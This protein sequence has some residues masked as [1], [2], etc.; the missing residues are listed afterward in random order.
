MLGKRTTGRVEVKPQTARPPQKRPGRKR[1]STWIVVARRLMLL[2][3]CVLLI[4][5][6]QQ[7]VERQPLAAREGPAIGSAT[8]WGYQLQNVRLKSISNGI[9]VLVVDYSRD[10]SEAR[11]FRRDEIE[12][13]RTKEDGSKRIV[14]AYMSVGEAE[15]Y[16][17]YWSRGWV[18]GKP[19]WLGPENPEWKG[20]FPVRYWEKGWRDIIMRPQVSL[21]E[22][23]TEAIRPSLRPYLDRIIEAGFDGV[24]LDRVDAFDSWVKENANAQADMAAFVGMISRYAKSRRAGFLIVPQNGEELLRFADYRRAIDAVAKEDLVYG[25]DGDGQPNNA[26]EVKRGIADLR[27]L[28]AEGRPVFVVE[29]LTDAAKRADAVKQVAPHGFVLHFAQRELRQIPE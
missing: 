12:A 24:Y 9:D 2:G 3:A 21:F 27:L 19:S 13:L 17:F 6:S 7:S 22:R 1:A 28:K 14:L 10:G 29:Y 16:R 4:A 25:V 18:P 23:F 20:N 8:S 5:F 11:V 26:G 15:N